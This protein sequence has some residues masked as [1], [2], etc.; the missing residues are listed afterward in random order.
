LTIDSVTPKISSFQFKTGNKLSAVPN[1]ADGAGISHFIVAERSPRF[2]CNR[3]ASKLATHNWYSDLNTPNLGVISL[4]SAASSPHFT[5]KVVNAQPMPP[6][7]TNKD[8]LIAYDMNYRACM[9]G[10]PGT[11][12]D[13]TL[14]HEDTWEL[15]QGSRT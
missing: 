11:L 15:L 14:T 1:Q 3:L 12:I 10:I 2:S 13:S 7:I 4:A 8:G 9:N 5:L 6:S